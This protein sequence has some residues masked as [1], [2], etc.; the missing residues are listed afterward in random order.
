MLLI[1]SSG[2]SSQVT[3]NGVSSNQGAFDGSSNSTQTLRFCAHGDNTLVFSDNGS[4]NPST[5]H[6]TAA[7]ANGTELLAS[8][9]SSTNPITFAV[10]SIQCNPDG[11]LGHSCNDWVG[12]FAP[13]SRGSAYQCS[14]L[15][16]LFQCDCTNCC[17]EETSYSTACTDQ[18]EGTSSIFDRLNFSSRCSTHTGTG[19]DADGDGCILYSSNPQYCGAS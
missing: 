13:L 10:T 2:T 17:D 15:V 8:T 9:P 6:F 3:I 5:S 14:D 4:F 7:M 1:Q 18:D 11:C 19:G 12:G 16:S